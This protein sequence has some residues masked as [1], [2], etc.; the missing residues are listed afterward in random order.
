[1]SRPTKRHLEKQ[2]SHLDGEAANSEARAFASKC[3]DWL[4][5]E[6][7]RDKRGVKSKAIRQAFYAC[8]RFS[9]AQRARTNPD[10]SVRREA[11]KTVRAAQH[12]SFPET[13]KRLSALH[14]QISKIGARAADR[15]REDAERTVV[16]SSRYELREMRSITSLRQVGQTLRNCAAKKEHARRYLKDADVEMWA[17]LRKR[18]P[19]SLLR[20]NTVTREV[21][22]F[23]AK[24]GATPKLKRSLAFRILDQ[25][26]VNG[27]DDEAF[28]RIGAFHAFRH[29]RPAATPVEA[30]DCKHWVWVLRDGA[31][32]VIASKRPGKRKKSWSRFTRDRRAVVAASWRNHLTG[33]RSAGSR[34]RPTM[35]R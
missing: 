21:E 14:G 35:A 23:E 33:R 28:V 18:Q 1:M 17:L 5:L 13:Q 7:N 16:L 6:S 25:L 30:G 9:Q 11:G 20:I 31:E 24:D 15:R 22:E 26:E 29:G 34:T 12:Q 27:D 4:K 32:V 3:R 10:S 19:V 2:L 8:V